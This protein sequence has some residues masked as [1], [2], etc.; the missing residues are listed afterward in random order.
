[1]EESFI[2]A[3]SFRGFS[4][5]PAG[6]IVF[7]PV[8]RKNIIVEGMME[9]N[10]QPTE[11]D[12]QEPVTGYNFPRHA[13]NDLITPGGPHILLSTTSQQCYHIVNPPRD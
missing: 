6:S 10:C 13:P 4:P 5:L 8:V 11:R 1:M 9:Q 12:R 3:H 7:G 2:L